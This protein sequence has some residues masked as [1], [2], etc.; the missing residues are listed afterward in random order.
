MRIRSRPISLLLAVV[1]GAG[2][3]HT[4]RADDPESEARLA[5]VRSILREAPL[6]DGHNDLP[7]QI[8]KRAGNLL[9][10]IDLRKDLRG[11][12]PTLHTDIPRLR[13]GGVGAQFWSVYIPVEFEGGA[14][15][16]TVIEQI[17]IV[18]RLAE[19]YPSDFEIALTAADVERV[20]RAGKI[21]A[22]IGMEGGHSIGNSLAV[23][24]QLYALGA[25]YMTITHWKEN[26][27]ADAATSP[28]VHDGLNA[29]G[30]AVIR[31]MN[32]LGMIVDLSH[33]SD[34]T[35]RDA[36]RVS[37]APV[38]FSHSSARALCKH[39]R[40]VPDDILRDLRESRGVV[41]VT[42]VTGYVSERVLE[43]SAAEEAE[44]ARLAE[45]HPGDSAE[46]A[47]ARIERWRVEN[48]RPKATLVDVADHIDHVRK[49]AGVDAIG[50]GSDFDGIRSTPSGLGDVSTFPDLLAELLR[51]GYSREDLEKIAG[52]NVLRV[53]RDVERVAGALRATTEPGEASIEPVLATPPVR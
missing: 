7:W 36:M 27:W 44:K 14:A 47:K 42:F 45:L 38:I 4:I 20:H 29:F 51:R 9:D 2:A 1:A 13:A 46:Q 5:A 50:I 41:M 6:V 33:V 12:E 18:H 52:G 10:K 16:Q 40:N 11:L 39:P 8:R 28:P 25:R 49:V 43:W 26:D 37:E 30:E 15:V 34:A 48:P 22:L 32:R 21:A 24:R 35:M 31:E 23:L 3:G 53:L 19:R 17:D